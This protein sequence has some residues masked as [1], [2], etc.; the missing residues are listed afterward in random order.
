MFATW[1]RVHTI[2]LIA[3]VLTDDQLGEAQWEFNTSCSMGW[4]R[5]WDKSLHRISP[6]QRQ[7]EQH[8][9]SMVVDARKKLRLW[10]YSLRC[11]AGRLKRSV[12]RGRRI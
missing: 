11:F 5:T 7:A 4:H 9:S 10:E 12:F 8:C 1:F 3:E 2:A 6:M